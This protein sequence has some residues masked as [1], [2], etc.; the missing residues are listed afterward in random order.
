[1]QDKC[2]PVLYCKSTVRVGNRSVKF[3][4]V[5]DEYANERSEHLNIPR[6]ASRVRTGQDERPSAH[7][8]CRHTPSRNSPLFFMLFCRATM[9]VIHISMSSNTFFISLLRVGSGF[10][11]NLAAAYVFAIYISP[12]IVL[13]TNN[14]LLCIVCLYLAVYLDRHADYE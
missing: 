8:T 11:T 4:L 10:F 1:M 14:V 5:S 12:N 7:L 9:Q 13:L 2:C 3:P 6:A